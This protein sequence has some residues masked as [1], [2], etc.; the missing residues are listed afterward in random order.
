MPTILSA[1]IGGTNSRFAVFRVPEGSPT[2]TAAGDPA[3]I[4]VRERR[5]KSR[6][7]PGF[8]EAVK[9]LFDPSPDGTPPLLDESARPDCI[10]LAPAGPVQ[11]GVCRMPNL[12]WVV[13]LS[14]IAALVPAPSL[15]MINDFAA[16]AYACLLPEA[17]EAVTALTGTPASGYPAA[18]MGAGTGFG[19]ALLLDA[20]DRDGSPAHGRRLDALRRI[21]V[22]PGEGGHAEVPFVG[23]DEFRFAEFAAKRM[24]TERLIGD[25]IV[26]GSG[27]ALLLAFHTGQE[28]APPQATPKALEHPEV[29]TWFARFYA[30]L[31]RNYMLQTLA[32]GGLYITGGMALRVPV[33]ENPAFRQEFRTCASHPRL[34]ENVPVWHIRRADQAGLWGAALY[35]LLHMKQQ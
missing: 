28:H 5:L 15:Y 8:T 21:R 10:V 9:A 22:L 4:L 17:V 29:L 33:L 20:P 12:H 30:R 11:D 34:F 32:L 23:K 18:V 1:D 31:C 3:L 7:Y 35:G 24:G 26:S 25:A 16:Q 27:L 19:Q 14:E 2:L 6:D 13:R